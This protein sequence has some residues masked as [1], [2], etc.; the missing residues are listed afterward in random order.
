MRTEGET[1]TQMRLVRNATHIEQMWTNMSLE[2][3]SCILPP[4][5]FKF[6][7]R[8]D[9]WYYFIMCVRRGRGCGG[10]G[11]KFGM[12]EARSSRNLLM[13]IVAVFGSKP[14]GWITEHAGVL[15]PGWYFQS[16]GGLHLSL[17]AY[18]QM[19]NKSA[20]RAHQ[21]CFSIFRTARF[22]V[23]SVLFSHLMHIWRNSTREPRKLAASSQNSASPPACKYHWF[24]CSKLTSS[25]PA[26]TLLYICFLTYFI[27][28]K[29]LSHCPFPVSWRWFRG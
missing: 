9:L 1:E 27:L 8:R 6:L 3:T 20:S 12:E 23:L 19:C 29:M 24:Y 18:F 4:Y 28:V 26:S 11:V 10:G 5:K 16:L 21:V 17:F 7:N 14:A 15:W 2:T 22:F 13:A 25:F